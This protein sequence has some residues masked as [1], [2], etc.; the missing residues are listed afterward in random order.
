MLSFLPDNP[1]VRGL[2]RE[3]LLSVLFF[4]ARQKYLLLYEKYKDIQIQKTTTGNKKFIAKI[5]EQMLDNLKKFK[6][7]NL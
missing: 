2:S 3:F 5:S 4:A 7:V 1:D 6:P